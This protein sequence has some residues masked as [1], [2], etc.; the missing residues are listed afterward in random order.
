M[1]PALAQAHAT[2]PGFRGTR[3]EAWNLEASLKEK[4]PKRLQMGTAI[5]H[6]AGGGYCARVW[7]GPRGL[8]HRVDQMRLNFLASDRPVPTEPH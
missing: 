8:G 3:K 1:H 2:L 4:C 5:R 6:R 7:G